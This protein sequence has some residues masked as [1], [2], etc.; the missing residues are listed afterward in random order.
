MY[1]WIK[2][3]H[4]GNLS[5]TNINFCTECAKKLDLSMHKCTI[6]PFL[7]NNQHAYSC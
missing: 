7:Q 3:I 6:K 4:H 5:F 2:Y 1:K